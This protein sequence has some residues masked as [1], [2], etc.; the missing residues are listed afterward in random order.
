MTMTAWQQFRRSHAI[1]K[2]L[3]FFWIFGPNF[4]SH[5]LWHE[6]L[7]KPN[8]SNIYKTQTSQNYHRAVAPAPLE[9]ENCG[10]MMNVSNRAQYSLNIHLCKDVSWLCSSM[11]V[12]SSGQIGSSPCWNCWRRLATLVRAPWGCVIINLAN[13][14][15]C[16]LW[17]TS[18]AEC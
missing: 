14:H 9:Y 3:N 8:L 13:R 4:S 18:V 6:W 5:F 1:G 11:H 10:L 7:P 2:F 16:T 15:F 17:N 12:Q